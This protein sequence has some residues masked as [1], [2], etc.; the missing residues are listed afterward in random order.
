MCSC[1]GGGGGVGRLEDT[2]S[3]PRSSLSVSG[4]PGSPPLPS[5][6]SEEAPVPG[7]AELLSL[8]EWKLTLKQ[9]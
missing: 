8:T 1:R 2:V 4:S 7:P 3:S 6:W 5:P 9:P